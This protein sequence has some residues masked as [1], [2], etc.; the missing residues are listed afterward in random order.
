MD[1]NSFNFFKSFLT[2]Y[3]K[4]KERDERTAHVFLD[5]IV[6]Y[7][8]TCEE[9]KFS[10]NDFLAELAW[11]GV[12]PILDQQWDGYQN[13]MKTGPSQT[14]PEGAPKG[15]SRQRKK[16]PTEGPSQ[17]PRQHKDK[18]KDKDKDKEMEEENMSCQTSRAW[19]EEDDDF[20]YRVLERWNYYTRGTVMKQVAELSEKRKVRMRELGDKHGESAVLQAFNKIQGSKFLRDGGPSGFKATFDWLTRP[21]NFE[22]LMNGEYDDF[23]QQ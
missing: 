14:P 1:R 15:V 21:D 18:D 11:D 4:I 20:F 6:T 7:G 23:K 22:K 13:A 2:Q 8:L 5:A 17:T 12:K 19:R 10:D 3:Q 9:P 16:T